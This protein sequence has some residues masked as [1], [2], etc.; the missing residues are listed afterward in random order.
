MLDVRKFRQAMMCQLTEKILM[1]GKTGALTKYLENRI[2]PK[3]LVLW[4]T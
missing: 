3:K 2:M 1:L 4:S